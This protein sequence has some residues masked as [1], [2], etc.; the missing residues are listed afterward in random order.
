MSWD[1]IAA[2]AAVNFDTEK[3]AQFDAMNADV[4]ILDSDIQRLEAVEKFEAEQRSAPRPNRAQPGQAIESTQVEER[5]AKEKRAFAQYITRGHSGVDAELREFVRENR[6]VTTGTTGANGGAL[7]PQLYHGV[8]TE[9]LK[10]FG[11]VSLLVGQKR[12]TGGQPLKIALSN[13]TGN[14][15]TVL[16]EATAVTE[17]DPAFASKILSTDTV[18]TGVIKVSIQELQDSYFDVDSWVRQAFG[19]RYGR[20]L[21]AMITNGN[22]SNVASL[23]TSANAAVTAKGNTAVSG[24]NG[25]NSIDY[26]DI[27]AMYGALDPAYISNA[28]WMFNSQTRAY[29]LGVKDSF[30]RPLYTPS[31]NS[32]AFDMLLGRPVVLNQALPNIAASAVGTVLFGAFDAGY[33]FRTDGDLS[34]LRLNERY[35]DTLEVGFI[36]YSRIGGISTDAG[37]HPIVALSQAAAS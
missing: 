19:Q 20:G 6:D 35:A 11:P 30:G 31:P 3:R 32:G 4:A 37:T 25:S 9:A 22:G 2:I 15:L 36:G 16:G 29:L 7:V 34:I 13:D 21:E 18:T 1:A 5:S 14:N 24:A 23:I 12:T 28:T 33:L 17:V 26:D 27:V 10:A 8:L